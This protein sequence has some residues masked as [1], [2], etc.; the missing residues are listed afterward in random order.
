MYLIYPS[1]FWSVLKPD[2]TKR[3]EASRSL[4]DMVYRYELDLSLQKAD[5][6][7]RG[8]S[9]VTRHARDEATPSENESLGIWQFQGR[10]TVAGTVGSFAEKL[11]SNWQAHFLPNLPNKVMT[12]SSKGDLVLKSRNTAPYFLVTE[13]TSDRITC[14]A[15]K[16]HHGI[17][18]ATSKGPSHAH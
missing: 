5:G 16:G 18:R 7:I 17:T 15:R 10:C 1:C 11:L 6:L 13:S 2:H 14:T 4:L 12:S 8:F 9:Q 3:R